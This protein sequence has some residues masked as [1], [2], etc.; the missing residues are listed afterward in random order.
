MAELA[1]SG[2]LNGRVKLLGLVPDEAL[3]DEYARASLLL[4]TSLEET[5]PV[6]LGEALAVGLPAVVTNAG[7]SPYMIQD[8]ETGFVCP[9]GDVQALARRVVELLRDA[10]LRRRLAARAREVGRQRFALDAIAAQTMAAYDEIL[11]G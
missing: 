2:R 10:E 7:G 5:A 11:G 3:W 8:G 1:R 9:V 6:A 4:L